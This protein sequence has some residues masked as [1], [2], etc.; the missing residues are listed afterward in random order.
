[1]AN[2]W[3]TAEECEYPEDLPRVCVV[4]GADSDT[5][6]AQKMSW[7][8]PYLKVLILAGPLPYLIIVLLL[9]KRMTVN[10]PVCEEHK[11]H[12]FK[13]KLIGIAA[14]LGGFAAL[15][16][17]MFGGF[18]VAE[19][20]R[21]LGW[22]GVAGTIVGIVFFVV[23]LVVAVVISHRM[24]RPLEITEDDIQLTRVSGAFADELKTVRRKRK[25]RRRD[26]DDDDEDYDPPPRRRSRRR[27][28]DEDD[29]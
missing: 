11:G 1:M 16:V 25:A 29:E 4:C 28:E 5:T 3:L 23:L 27:Y 14:A 18:I 2:V 12:W 9:T 19:Q 6:V 17:C 13:H 10:A 7:Y 8:P 22:V 20:D 21:D 26:D 15:F 24:V